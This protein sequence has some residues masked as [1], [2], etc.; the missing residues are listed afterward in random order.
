MSSTSCHLLPFQIYIS[1][2]WGSWGEWE[3]CTRSCNVG[4]KIK[5]RD[6]ENGVIG[7]IGCDTNNGHKMHEEWECCYNHPCS[8]AWPNEKQPNNISI[9]GDETEINGNYNYW[10]LLNHI[11]SYK[12]EDCVTEDDTCKYIYTDGKDWKITNVIPETV[13]EHG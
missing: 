11:R 3:K 7:D 8:R 9:S 2:T 10:K 1:A 12:R 13:G 4:I 5:R 6:C